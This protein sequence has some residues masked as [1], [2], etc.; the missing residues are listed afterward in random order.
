[1]RGT[2]YMIFSRESLEE[3]VEEYVNTKYGWDVKVKL[4]QRKHHNVAMFEAALLEKNERNSTD[5]E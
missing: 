4:Q 1:M 5:E 2:N 3:I